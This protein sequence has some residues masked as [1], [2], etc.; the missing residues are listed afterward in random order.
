MDT[1]TWT[2]RIK[3][4]LEVVIPISPARQA[5]LTRRTRFDDLESEDDETVGGNDH[6]AHTST[7]GTVGQGVRSYIS[8][9]LVNTD[10]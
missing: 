8:T 5:I 4:V 1:R 6:S 2:R 3:R 10:L 9:L 7:S